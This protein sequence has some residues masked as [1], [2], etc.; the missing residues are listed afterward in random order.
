EWA[1]LRDMAT[2][3]DSTTLRAAY[4]FSD[5]RFDGDPA[6]GNNDIPGAPPH[7]LRAELIYRHPAGWYAGPGVEWVPQAYYVDNANTLKT[8]PYALLGAKAGY[9]FGNGVTVFL[10]GRNLLDRTFISNVGTTTIANA[11]SALFNP[12]DGRAVYG[13]LEL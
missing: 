12:G 10:D 1:A 8:E 4:T 11:G 7:Y 6:F 5:F 13:G 3:G 2:G 9:D